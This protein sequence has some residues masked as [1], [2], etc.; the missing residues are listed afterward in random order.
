MPQDFLASL[1]SRP[2]GE[3]GVRAE[4]PGAPPQG[5]MPAEVAEFLALIAAAEAAR[6][7]PAAPP[8]GAAPA[9]GDAESPDDPLAALLSA[10]S[11]EGDDTAT[12]A[13]LPDWLRR[14]LIGSRKGGATDAEG[15]TGPALSGVSAAAGTAEPG[16]GPDG[17]GRLAIVARADGMTGGDVPDGAPGA[18]EMSAAGSAEIRDGAIGVGD[19][20]TDGSGDV[21]DSGMTTAEAAGTAGSGAQGVPDDGLP[22]GPDAGGRAAEAGRTP[23]VA[24]T[25]VPTGPVAALSVPPVG[26]VEG[27]RERGGESD[28]EAR[29][30]GA[31]PGRAAAASAFVLQPAPAAHL[32]SAAA[33]EPTASPAPAAAGIATDAVSPDAADLPAVRTAA[34]VSDGAGRPEV[35]TPT[36]APAPAPAPAAA[37]TIDAAALTAAGA[38]GEALPTAAEPPRPAAPPPPVALPH[39]RDALA[40]RVR[41]LAEEAGDDA[42]RIRTASGTAE[43]ELAPAELGRLRLQL[44]TTERGLHLTVFVDRPESIDAVRRHLD[45]LHR[46]LMAEGVTLDGFDIG[47]GGGAGA[48]GQ[49]QAAGQGRPRQG[50]PGPEAGPGSGAPAPQADAEAPPPAPGRTATGR[51]DIRI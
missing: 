30:T 1:S 38:A 48:R 51:L 47:T 28:A 11:P 7:A 2:A 27:G 17:A 40:E 43:V 34:P 12:G 24:S 10:F 3:A 31:S 8:V 20:S 16:A 41:A 4:T 13:A 32:P 36:P 39:L 44:S 6:D 29:R 18:R 5:A 50:P 15:R 45:G 46:S 21:R 26:K 22:D 37:T 9:G 25:D 42:V 14:A 33:P 23:G 49:E 35:P 19:A